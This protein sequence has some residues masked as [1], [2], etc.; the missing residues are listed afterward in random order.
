MGQH[1]GFIWW[2]LVGL[3]AGIL[4]KALTPGTS[5]EPG[6]CVMTI[7]LG[8]A[9]SLIVGF[10]VRTFMG[11][12]NGGFISSIV[13]ATLGAIILIILARKLWT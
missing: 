1:H 13:G 8:I 7:V 6:G 12:G 3:I 9:G 11:G 10:L 4:A 5:K 2:I